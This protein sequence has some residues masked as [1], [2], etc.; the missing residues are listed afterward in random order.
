[1]TESEKL[2]KRLELMNQELVKRQGKLKRHRK[3]LHQTKDDSEVQAI[4]SHRCKIESYKHPETL[5]SEQTNTCYLEKTEKYPEDNNLSSLT[6]P[7]TEAPLEE[8]GKTFQS[9]SYQDTYF[10]TD[11]KTNDEHQVGTS[12]VDEHAGDESNPLT[13]ELL[14]EQAAL[15]E[16]SFQLGQAQPKTPNKALNCASSTGD[17]SP[18]LTQKSSILKSATKSSVRY[19]PQRKMKGLVTSYQLRR[20]NYSRGLPFIRCPELAQTN[21]DISSDLEDTVVNNSGISQHSLASTIPVVENTQIQMENLMHVKSLGFGTST[22][23][24]SE[25]KGMLLTVFC[26]MY[27]FILVQEKQ[28]S[29]WRL[30]GVREPIWFHEGYLSRETIFD[31]K[32]LG[33]AGNTVTVGNENTFV[34]VELWTRKISMESSTFLVIVY[35]YEEITKKFQSY[36]LQLRQFSGHIS[37]MKLCVHPELSVIVSWMNDD[38]STTSINKFSL[39]NGSKSV[40]KTT[41]L[42]PVKEVLN[43]L[44]F[45][46]G[47][48]AVILG[49]NDSNIYIWEHCTGALVKIIQCPRHHTK[50]QYFDEDQGFLFVSVCTETHIKLLVVNL[51]NGKW[52]TLRQI[53]IPQIY[54]LTGLKVDRAKLVAVSLEGIICWDLKTGHCVAEKQSQHKNVSSFLGE[55]FSVHISTDFKGEIISTHFLQTM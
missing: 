38:S 16:W 40:L 24:L 34:C 13:G 53:E 31:G 14:H 37:N 7:N 4:G 55:H 12:C 35:Y 48:W 15:E 8:L 46:K 42:S 22:V 51:T 25:E 1:M 43:S 23:E 41:E 9:L 28:L 10:H 21:K 29:I 26:G 2:K 5:S 32:S 6:V 11:N 50:M 39:D 20:N 45:I 19:H 17:I 52:K 27:Y 18:V 30:S 3:K 47:C 33:W 49:E 54:K 36:C 44:H